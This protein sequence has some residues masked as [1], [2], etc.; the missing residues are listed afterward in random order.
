MQRASAVA[1]RNA[2]RAKRED[3]PW[4][5]ML[6]VFLVIVYLLPFYVLLNLSLRTLTD[7]GSRLSMPE[8][9]NWQNYVDVLKSSDLWMGFQN[10]VIIA[11]ETI[12]V[13]ICLGSLAAYGL[14]R[15]S[16]R[17]TNSFRNVNMGIMMI[18][19]LALLVGTYSL[20]SKLHL[21]N[22]LWGL[23]LLSAAGGLPG[24][25]F[26]Y[27]NFITAIPVALDEAATIDGASVSRTFFQIILPQLKPITVTRIIMAFVGSWNNYLMPMYLLTNKAKYTV[28]LVIKLA[29]ST[30]N[31][32]GNLPVAAATCA[33][34]LLPVIIIYLCLQRYIIQGQLDSAVK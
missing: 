22:S 9:F 10:S 16:N 20:M 18:P 17:F 24:T 7:L 23:A 26:F 1:P 25:I 5:Y 32:T 2:I 11:M 29:F 8:V 30:G 33:L 19:G 15:T 4:H 34:G 27:T 14:A 3:R 13:E 28:I 31:G 21:V 12:A 6:A